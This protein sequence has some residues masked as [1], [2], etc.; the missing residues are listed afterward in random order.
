M[1][2]NETFVLHR[3][4]IHTVE[5]LTD[6]QA[7]D[8]LK[9]ILRYVNDLNPQTD[10]FITKL[11]FQPVRQQIE[12]DLAKRKATSEK[13]RANGKKGGRPKVTRNTTKTI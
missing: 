10:N 2:N 12:N 5:H 3:D 11:A 6:E 7:G 1:K 13:N 4:L 8:L 9:H